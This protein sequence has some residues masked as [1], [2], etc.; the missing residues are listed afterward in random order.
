M[1]PTPL[2]T[3]LHPGGVYRLEYPAHWDQVQ[4][5]E[6]RSCGFG[7]HER[8]DV[9]LWI[10]IMPVSID[11]DRLAQELPRMMEMVTEKF[12][13]T[14]P[15][16]DPS[17]KHHAYRADSRKDGE[18]GHYWIVAGGDIVLFASSQ[19]PATERD[20]WNPVFDRLMASLTI[21][22]DNE[23]VM[24]QVA[25]EVLLQLRERHP[26][27]EFEFDEKGRIR[28]KNRAVFLSNL[29][30]EV[31]AAPERREKIIRHYV[32]HLSSATEQTMGEEV[33]EECRSHILPV[34]KP[35]QYIVPNSPTEHILTQEWLTDVIICYVIKN[36]K[37]FRF[38]TGWDVRRWGTTDEALH[39]L[40]V[41]NL[42]RL[43][44]PKQMEGARQ[45]DGGR[46]IIV[47]TGD[48]L[49]SSRLLNPELHQLFSGPLGSPF[50]AGIPDRDTLVVYSDRRSLKQRI[51]RRLKKDYDSSAYPI[52]P[53]PFLVTR[54][55]IAAGQG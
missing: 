19:V 3:F 53:K 55:G 20:V 38:V 33:W 31:L 15:Q 17:L 5:E 25:N 26:D 42:R 4:Q 39:E 36:E 24:R 22:R 29:Y 1:L 21:T 51:A 44:W 13:V 32:E 18:A 11:T 34:L 35:K 45:K 6:G 41:E 9:G 10:S 12:E 49:A 48:S 47:E 16:P 37:L 52:T 27:Q 43:S 2:K 7:P 28:G 40:A 8:D 23:L 54:D 46:I 30:R 14:N 50:W